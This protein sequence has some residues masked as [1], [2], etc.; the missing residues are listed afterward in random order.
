M[1]VIKY[2]PCDNSLISQR[3]VVKKIFNELFLKYLKVNDAYDT[4]IKDCNGKPYINGIEN[5]FSISHSRGMCAVA[6]CIDSFA[7][8]SSEDELIFDG[9]FINVGVDVQIVPD[10]CKNNVYM[11]IAEKY[12]SAQEVSYL[13]NINSP[14]NFITS[15][16]KLWTVKESYC[17]MKGLGLK[18]IRQA[19]LD[20]KKCLDVHS[21]DICLGENNYFISFC[22]EKK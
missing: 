5:A 12:F 18:F 9:G 16:I 8:K 2:A 22:A 11:K 7:N 6:L 10:L 20:D 3:T 17:K 15:F 4:I 1:L 21:C 14:E 13:S 19:V